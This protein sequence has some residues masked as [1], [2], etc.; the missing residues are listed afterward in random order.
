[1]IEMKKE[2]DAAK[3]QQKNKKLL[4]TVLWTQKQKV[5]RKI[6]KYCTLWHSKGNKGRPKKRRLDNVKIDC[7]KKVLNGAT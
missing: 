2:L 3:N 4:L 5:C 1:M 7:E 6:T